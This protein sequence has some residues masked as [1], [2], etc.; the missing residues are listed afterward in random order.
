MDRSAKSVASNG[1]DALAD[2]L[3]FG[4]RDPPGKAF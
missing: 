3:R 1:L 2:G 4:Q